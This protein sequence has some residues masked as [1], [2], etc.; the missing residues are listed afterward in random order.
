VLH[1][2]KR[3][4]RCAR[5]EQNQQKESVTNAVAHAQGERKCM[6]LLPEATTTGRRRANEWALCA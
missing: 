3:T 2:T 4:E 6:T 1:L 5:S